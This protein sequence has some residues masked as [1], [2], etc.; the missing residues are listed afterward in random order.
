MTTPKGGPSSFTTL[1]T[2][3][4]DILV[5]F[6]FWPSSSDFLFFFLVVTAHACTFCTRT[7]SLVVVVPV[8][9]GGVVL[10]VVLVPDLPIYFFTM[11]LST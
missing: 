1:P 5:L 3:C 4:P 2:P 9:V 11:P 10:A 8:V 6:A 7:L